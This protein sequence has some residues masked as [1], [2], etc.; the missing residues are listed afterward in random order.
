MDAT[1]EFATLT[2][3]P[4]SGLPVAHIFKPAEIDARESMTLSSK[5]LI[6][7]FLTGSPR[8]QC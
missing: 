7:Q 2:I 4:E 6:A 1:V 8:T 5:C 3:D